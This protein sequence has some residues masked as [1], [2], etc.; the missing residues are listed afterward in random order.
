VTAASIFVGTDERGRVMEYFRDPERIDTVLDL[1]EDLWRRHR[2]LSM[3]GL[4][5]LLTLGG[6]RPSPGRERTP[7]Y[8]G[9]THGFEDSELVQGLRH[10]RRFGLIAGADLLDKLHRSEYEAYRRHTNSSEVVS[11]NGYVAEGSAPYDYFAERLAGWPRSNSHIA[12]CVFD[13]G[14]VWKRD[15]EQRFGQQVAN[16]ERRYDRILDEAQRYRYSEVDEVAA[17]AAY[18][19]AIIDS[20]LFFLRLSDEKLLQAKF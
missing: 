9:R 15:P 11:Q 1:F 14:W 20:N 6:F 18:D 5:G 17:Q 13:F 8:N 12:A 19:R 4:T 16:M 2:R 3:S 10:A 7:S